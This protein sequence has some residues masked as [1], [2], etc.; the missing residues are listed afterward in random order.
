MQ[1]AVAAARNGGPNSVGSL[2]LTLDTLGT[3]LAQVRR[4]SV[5]VSCV[6]LY[7]AAGVCAWHVCLCVVATFCLK[8]ARASCLSVCCRN[9]QISYVQ[10]GQAGQAVIA[11]E[12]CLVLWDQ[13]LKRPHS[14][15][16][17]VLLDHLGRA[18]FDAANYPRA[19]KVLTECC[20]LEAQHGM[21]RTP[22]HATSLGSLGRALLSAG[23]TAQA[24]EVL[25]KTRQLKI[26]L[27][28]GKTLS[29]TITLCNLGQALTVADDERA[30]ETLEACAALEREL[31]LCETQV[32]CITISNLGC[33]LLLA[34]QFH[35][36]VTVLDQA[37]E[38][39]I[40]LGLHKLPGY[41]ICLRNLATALE[42]AGQA[43]RAAKVGQQAGLLD[44]SATDTAPA[45]EGAPVQVGAPSGGAPLDD[46]LVKLT[47]ETAAQRRQRVRG[48]LVMNG[49]HV[50]RG[51]GAKTS[52]SDAGSLR[53]VKSKAPKTS[54]GPSAPDGKP[55]GSRTTLA[56]LIA[57][58]GG[59]SDALPSKSTTTSPIKATNPT[60]SRTT[61]A[62]LMA[63]EAEMETT[64][65]GASDGSVANDDSSTI[66][67]HAL[68]AL[69]RPA[70]A[71]NNSNS[72]SSNINNNNNANSNNTSNNAKQDSQ[73]S[74]V[75]ESA[76]LSDAGEDE[77]VLD[78]L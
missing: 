70:G 23:D 29:F 55:V 50:S 76:P 44:T 17:V 2:L 64:K 33:A 72:S 27:G 74:S 37:C 30:V 49:K 60:G 54:G 45:A 57:M 46:V 34:D 39:K 51:V 15:D 43:D 38:L 66:V 14:V 40:K 71:V 47:E 63:V 77:V 58:D 73:H 10:A 36:A 35:R 1:L 7:V 32:H 13:H 61:L 68:T 19:V 28:L 48:E 18:L 9:S 11:H 12:E 41:V 25:E 53:Q 69:A 3:V 56:D 20:K 26:D 6:G 31:G 78:Y 75:A 8:L 42:H 62:E 4:V 22:A 52:L 16:Y 59:S 5:F 24:L 67:V 21:N 65:G